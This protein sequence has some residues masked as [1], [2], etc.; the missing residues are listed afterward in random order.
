MY[1]LYKIN[2]DE[3][4]DNFITAIKALFPHQKIEISI[5]QSAEI[6]QNETDYLLSHPAN[7][8]RLLAAIDNVE[9]KNWVDIDLETL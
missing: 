8:A 4:N 6:E 3:L 9:M 2:S 1:T 7:K 5:S